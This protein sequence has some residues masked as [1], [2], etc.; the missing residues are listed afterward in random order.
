MSVEPGQVHFDDATT[1]R[2]ASLTVTAVVETRR[3][4]VDFGSSVP[5]G[6]PASSTAGLPRRDVHCLSGFDPADPRRLPGSPVPARTAAQ[7]CAL[8]LSD[9]LRATLRLPPFPFPGGTGSVGGCILYTADG[10]PNVTIHDAAQRSRASFEDRQLSPA[11]MDDGILLLAGPP[12]RSEQLVG[13]LVDTADGP[14]EVEIDGVSVDAIVTFSQALQQAAS[15][16]QAA[17]TSEP[18]GFHAPTV[19]PGPATKLLC[20]ASPLMVSNCPVG[21]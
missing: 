8:G 14:I 17:P 20:S 16:P 4:K 5:A 19:S 18:G 21:Q 10:S 6:L 12:G 2:K 7:L 13:A 3:L 9:P 1:A 11:Y 15:V